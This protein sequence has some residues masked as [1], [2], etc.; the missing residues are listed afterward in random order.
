MLAT[1]KKQ[2]DDQISL[3]NPTVALMFATILANAGVRLPLSLRKA[4]YPS[5]LQNVEDAL[6]CLH[7]S[8]NLEAM[9]LTVQLLIQMDRLDLARCEW[10]HGA[11]P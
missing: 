7:N 4:P 1:V 3:T 5:S 8:D 11:E 9:A 2:M 6:R 10:S